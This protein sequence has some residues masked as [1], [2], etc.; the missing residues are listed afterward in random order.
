MVLFLCDRD[1]KSFQVFNSIQEICNRKW[2]FDI[3]EY[4]WISQYLNILSKILNWIFEYLRTSMDLVLHANTFLTYDRT[5]DSLPPPFS[6][7]SKQSLEHSFIRL[8]IEEFWKI[9]LNNRHTSFDYKQI[10]IYWN[11]TF[12]LTSRQYLECIFGKIEFRFWCTNMVWCATIFSSLYFSLI[13]INYLLIHYNHCNNQFIY[14]KRLLFVYF[15][16]LHWN[17]FLLNF[18]NILKIFDR[19]ILSNSIENSWN[20]ELYFVLW[21]F[22]RYF[23]FKYQNSN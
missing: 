7:S 19:E 23:F 3:F 13:A 5:S 6:S 15:L 20:E 12:H 22:C 16:K 18:I 17:W 21:L 14:F 9:N 1:N 4:Q 10:I 2:N 11:G 8:L